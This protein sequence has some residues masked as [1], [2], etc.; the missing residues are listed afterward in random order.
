MYNSLSM[1]LSCKF[2]LLVLP[3]FLYLPF[4]LFHITVNS[5]FWVMHYFNKIYTSPD[6]CHL[7]YNKNHIQSLTSKYLK[8]ICIK[9]FQKRLN[10]NFPCVYLDKHYLNWLGFCCY[11][12]QQLLFLLSSL[13]VA[14]INGLT[15]RYQNPKVKG[16]ENESL[17]DKFT[18]L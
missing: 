12:Y 15:K 1:S 7:H 10:L 14:F 4:H 6:F 16:R 17:K 2:S 11:L 13:P 18:N 9:K 5:P 3:S 8:L